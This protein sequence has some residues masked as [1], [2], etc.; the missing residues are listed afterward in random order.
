MTTWRS[1]ATRQ[2]RRVSAV[3]D[4][5]IDMNNFKA[6]FVKYFIAFSCVFLFFALLAKYI[7]QGKI[8]L[9]YSLPFSVSLALLGAALAALFIW[10]I[11][12]LEAE[13]PRVQPPEYL[14]VDNKTINAKLSKI[15]RKR[16]LLFLMFCMWIPFGMIILALNLPTFYIFGYM[17]ALAIIAFVL[18]FARCPR[19]GHY[20]QFRGALQ[21]HIGDTGSEKINLLV[22]G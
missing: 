12:M 16:I 15:R 14:K 6:V 2:G 20:F 21:G 10:G 9:K 1:T 18:Q 19:C 17:A 5:K 13:P 4:C 7:G 11:R 8:D 3:L 22:G